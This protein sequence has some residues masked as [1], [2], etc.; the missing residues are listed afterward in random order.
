[1]T[2][3]NTLVSGANAFSSLQYGIGISDNGKYIVGNGIVSS[4]GQ[5]HGFLLA[6]A[7][8]GDANGDR[9]VDISDLTIVLASYDRGAA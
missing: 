5:T 2:D 1:M 4:S 6:A 3:L 7:L 9:K 8:P